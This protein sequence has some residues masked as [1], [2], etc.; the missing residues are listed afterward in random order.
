VAKQSIGVGSSANDGNGDPL[1]TAGSKINGNFDELYTLLGDGS[2][3]TSDTVIL[4]TATQTLTNKTITG[5]FTGDLTGNVT[6]DLTGDVTGDLTGN[7][8]GNVTGDLT[9]DVT[10]DLTGNV[11][12]NVNSTTVTVSSNVNVGGSIVFEGAT[13][14]TNEITLTPED[15][16]ADAT[17]ILPAEDGTLATEGFSIAVSVALG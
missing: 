17:L 16:S 10:G 8:T 1:R 14:D 13:E 11:T 4:N 6:G 7:V 15:P 9:G 3:L 12:G 5:D 2:T